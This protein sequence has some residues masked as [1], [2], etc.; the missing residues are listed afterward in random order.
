M[1][2]KLNSMPD[3]PANVELLDSGGMQMIVDGHVHIGGLDPVWA[4][5]RLTETT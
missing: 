4:K 5:H 1:F 3:L 2:E